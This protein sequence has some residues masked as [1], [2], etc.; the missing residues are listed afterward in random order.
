MAMPMA[1]RWATLRAQ[2]RVP[3]LATLWAHQTVTLWALRSGLQLGPQSVTLSAMPMVHQ[4]E[5]LKATEKARQ[6]GRH[7]AQP[8]VTWSG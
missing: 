2:L 7:S 5:P 1:Q 4:T 6:T 3:M 8:K